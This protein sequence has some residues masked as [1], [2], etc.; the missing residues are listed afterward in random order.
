[1]THD[2][3]QIGMVEGEVTNRQRRKVFDKKMRIVL[4]IPLEPILGKRRRCTHSQG[5]ERIERHVLVF[6]ERG[7]K[8]V[9]RLSASLKCI[10][11]VDELVRIHRI[12][13]VRLK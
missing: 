8:L 1:M 12:R 7:Q 5:I 4:L 3:L 11:Y 9:G 6:C 10:W 2:V 13:L